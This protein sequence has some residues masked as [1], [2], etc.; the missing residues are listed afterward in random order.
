MKI[1]V[2][3]S[4]KS[5]VQGIIHLEFVF[6]AC[7]GCAK[8]AATLNGAFFWFFLLGFG[9]SLCMEFLLLIYMIDLRI[10]SKK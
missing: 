3:K 7:I 9:V 8:Y 2:S 10:T 6:F 4:R 5:I 1:T